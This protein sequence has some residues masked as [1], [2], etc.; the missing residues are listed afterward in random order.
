M[1]HVCA[2]LML[3]RSSWCLRHV[4]ERQPHSDGITIIFHFCGKQVKNIDLWPS[5]SIMQ[6]CM[7]H[8]WSIL[9]KLKA[10]L[11]Q[12]FNVCKD[13]SPHKLSNILKNLLDVVKWRAINLLIVLL[14][15][16]L[17]N[18]CICLLF[19]FGHI[20]CIGGVFVLLSS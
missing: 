11:I 6:G 17:P 19:A 3:A 14:T 5:S 20:N 13:L 1:Q 4:L 2:Y 18:S 16:L 12:N 10:R 8:L 7:A 15:I 9:G